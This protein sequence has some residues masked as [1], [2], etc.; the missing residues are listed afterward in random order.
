M[1][2]SPTLLLSLSP[3]P[4][5]P[6]FKTRWKRL[7]KI[8]GSVLRESS[9]LEVSCKY[10]AYLWII[11]SLF[12]FPFHWTKARDREGLEPPTNRHKIPKSFAF[13]RTPADLCKRMETMRNSFSRLMVRIVNDFPNDLD[14]FTHLTRRE[15]AMDGII[16]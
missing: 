5:F 7:Q 12:S 2:F 3:S 16:G 15:I 6:S 9:Y 4:P 10:R 8:T 1:G 14:F 13:P 11:F